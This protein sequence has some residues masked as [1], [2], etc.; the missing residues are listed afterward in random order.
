MSFFKSKIGKRIVLIL[1]LGIAGLLL[2]KNVNSTGTGLS[3]FSLSKSESSKIDKIFISP[4]NRDKNYIILTKKSKDQWTVT[5]GSET[6]NTDTQYVYRILN[7]LLPR[8][9]VKNPVPNSALENVERDMALNANKVVFYNG[10]KEIKTIFIGGGTPDGYATHMHLPGKD[11]PS[12]IEIPGFAG[13][14]DIYFNANINNWKSTVLIDYPVA[15]IAKLK[16]EWPMEPKHNF[17]IT[18]DRTGAKITGVN[19]PMQNI[20]KNTL[21]TYLNMF[22]KLSR[23]SGATV[24]VNTNEELKKDV[25]NGGILFSLNITNSRGK[26][27]VLDIYR[28]P[29][30]S[31]TYRISKTIGSLKDYETDSYFAKLNKGNEFFV[32]QDIVWNKVMKKASDFTRK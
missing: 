27:E 8:L 19:G 10:K 16:I 14:L 11:R 23:E 5:N 12:V 26:T 6:Y 2:W 17:L 22:R 3:D 24:G 13:T 30:S 18:N 28:K 29:V 21:L 15:D 25:L 20:S 31:E 7:W 9:Q 4:N 1:I 32:V